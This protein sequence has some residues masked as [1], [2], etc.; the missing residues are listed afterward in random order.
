MRTTVPTPTSRCR[1]GFARADVT[2]PVGMYHR[3]WGAA[4][5]DVSTGVHRPLTA[6][7][8]AFA[9][10]AETGARS[11]P[12]VLL[13]LD[14]CLLWTPDI[15]AIRESIL[16]AHQLQPTDLVI[17][18]SHTHAAGLMDPTR[19]ELPGGDR[20][21]PY[22]KTLSSQLMEITAEALRSLA[23]ATVSYARGRSALAAHRDAW[24]EAS[25][26]FVC[27]LN[28][29]GAGDD[30][31][32][33]ARITD[34]Q[35]QL[36]GT[37]VNYACHPTTLAWENTLI[38]PDFPGALR[39]TMESQTTAPCVFLQGA[40]GDL[41][42]RH[43]FV[44]D[45]AVA[46]KNGRELAYA[47]L[48]ALESLGPAGSDFQYDG[49]VISGATLG[50]WSYHLHNETR[51]QAAEQFAVR[52][53]V[54]PLPYIADRPT[55]ERLEVDRGRW[56]AEEAEARQ[57]GDEARIRDCRAMVERLNRA[58]TRWSSV[59]EGT[60]FPYQVTLL[61]MGDAVWVTAEGE[62]YQLL[63]T[64]L[65]RR[66]PEL[67]I[68]VMMLG[69]GWRCSYLPTRETYGRGIYQEQ[70]ALLAAGALEQLIDATAAAIS[71][72]TAHT[73]AGPISTGR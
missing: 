20:I 31:L 34:D 52:R 5:H 49:P 55:L 10:L 28:P 59:P 53:L 24:D 7:A 37:I 38:S 21:A 51:Q 2:P 64:E 13:A 3:M 71:E 6:S 35:G 63:Q 72:M 54:A 45:S 8:M 69:D 41:G 22:L 25:Q 19:R 46:D 14:H 57:A 48:A 16:T 56:T 11:R 67:T 32:I 60:E 50:V 26:Q 27:G 1:F 12:F 36:R 4:T 18:F 68:V 42:P 33:V 62:P 70:I 44:G 65:R 58:M 39:E 73:L 29:E 61:R 15:A 17:T 9:P 23:P 43:G 40:S 47:S 30:T 66:F